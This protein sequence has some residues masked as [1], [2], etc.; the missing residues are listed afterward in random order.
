[1]RVNTVVER[2]GGAVQF[3]ADLTPEETT[4]LLEY[5]INHLMMK[6]AL[7]FTTEEAHPPYAIMEGTNTEQ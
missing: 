7:P 2:D 3:T 4:F 1:M 6:G 5:S